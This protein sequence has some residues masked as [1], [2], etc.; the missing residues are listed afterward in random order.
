MARKKVTAKTTIKVMTGTA[1]PAGAD[2]IIKFEDVRR[3][4]NIC[5]FFH[6]SKRAAISCR[7]ARM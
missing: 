1:I 4:G 6:R 7:R 5:K 2:A 3:A